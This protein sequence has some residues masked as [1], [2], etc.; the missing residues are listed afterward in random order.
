MISTLFPGPIG[1]DGYQFL[2]GGCSDQEVLRVSHGNLVRTYTVANIPTVGPNLRFQLTHNSRD[3]FLG[4]LGRNWRHNGMAKLTFAGVP[5]NLVTFTDES[6]RPYDFQWNAASSTWDLTVDSLF[7]R[8]TLTQVGAQWHL[9][10]FA[11]GDTMIFDSLGQ[12]EQ[13][14]NSHGQALTFSHSGGLL[15]AITEPTGRALTL[16]YTA[17]ML[18]KVVDPNSNETLFGMD[19]NSNLVSII[20]PDGCELS[21]GYAPGSPTA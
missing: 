7:L 1:L 6:G 14:V 11:D 21:Y 5:V 15:T 18:T 9:A 20:G 16:T 17:G 3:N 19:A 10:E 8:K 13:I 2:L 12:L 4:T